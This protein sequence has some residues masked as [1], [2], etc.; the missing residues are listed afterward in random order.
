MCIGARPRRRS[1][2]VGIRVHDDDQDTIIEVKRYGGAKTT[3]EVAAQPSRCDSS[4][5]KRRT[6][7]PVPMAVVA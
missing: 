3:A 6:P 1:C 4:A 7:L 2:R 5:G